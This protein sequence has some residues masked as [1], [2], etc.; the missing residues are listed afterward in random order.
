[1]FDLRHQLSAKQVVY[2]DTE[3]TSQDSE[4]PRSELET[5]HGGGDEIILQNQLETELDQLRQH[6][7]LMES[8]NTRLKALVEDMRSNAVEGIRPDQGMLQRKV[9]ACRTGSPRPQTVYHQQMLDE[10][11]LHGFTQQ[12]LVIIFY[13]PYSCIYSFYSQLH[14]WCISRCQTKRRHT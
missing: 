14:S 12:H 13:P 6:Y 10:S 5:S 9:V 1:V 3:V 4:T 8:E 2:E 11:R 7:V